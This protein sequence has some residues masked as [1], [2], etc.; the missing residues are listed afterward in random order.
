ML[1]E[2]IAGPHAITVERVDGDIT[3]PIACADIAGKPDAGALVLGLTAIDTGVLVGVATLS[4]GD[5]GDT[6]VVVYLILAAN[7]DPLGA[8]GEDDTGT[9]DVSGDESDATDDDE[10]APEGGV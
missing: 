10:A 3:T 2:I 7:G 4:S 6:N 8:T 5:A 1:P 9:D